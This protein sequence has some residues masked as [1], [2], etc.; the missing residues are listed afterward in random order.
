MLRA[1]RVLHRLIA[2]AIACSSA[3]AAHAQ[4]APS[5]PTAGPPAD[6][7]VTA[8]PNDLALLDDGVARLAQ[9]ARDQGREALAAKDYPLALRSLQRAHDLDRTHADT[10]VRLAELYA[11]LGNPARAEQ[12]YREAIAIDPD[13]ADSHIG[14]AEQLAR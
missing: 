3:L 6:A 10:A 1:R 11:L 13:N 14:L 12:I 7:G 2:T 8:E 4:Q 5:D 9:A